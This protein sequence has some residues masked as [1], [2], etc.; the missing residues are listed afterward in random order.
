[1]SNLAMGLFIVVM[2]LGLGGMLL[3]LASRLQARV[4]ASRQWSEVPAVIQSARLQKVGKTS[5]APS[6]TYSYTVAGKSYT[7]KRLQL[8]G[9]N[10]T[11]EQ[12]EEVLAAYPVGSTT[13]VRY[14]PQ[15]HDFAILRLGADT[16]GLRFAGFAL[17]GVFA[18]TGLI[19]AF[20]S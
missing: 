17:G 3:Y 7:G 8:G 16:K 20:V 12:A 11:R 10:M 2:G 6:L 1:M 14:N 19:V 5:S 4:E 15:Q 13:T 18:V 9:L